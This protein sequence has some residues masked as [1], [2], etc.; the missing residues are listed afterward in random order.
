MR[1][2]AHLDTYPTRILRA[3]VLWTMAAAAETVTKPAFC[4][5][6]LSPP[7]CMVTSRAPIWSRCSSLR[8]R[9]WVLV[10]II[11]RPWWTLCPLVYG[12]G[13]FVSGGV[14]ITHRP[15][16]THSAF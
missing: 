7:C 6:A 2:L 8:C 12:R 9:R 1:Q 15:I 10:E 11:P 3:G 4:G 5:F 16:C 14:L 13:E